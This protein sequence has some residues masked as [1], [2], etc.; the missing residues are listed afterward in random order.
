[1]SEQVDVL[2]GIGTNINPEANIVEAIDQLRRLFGSVDVSTI[3]TSAPVGRVDQ[4]TFLNG[5]VCI[6][7][8]LSP[9]ELKQ[10]LLSIEASQGRIRDPDDKCGPRTIDLDIIAYG[11]LVDDELQIPDSNL[12]KRWFVA[13]PCAELSPDWLHPVIGSTLHEIAAGLSDEI[14]G[15]PIS[16]D[17]S[18]RAARD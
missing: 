15:S 11:S 6:R 3:Y 12:A 1:M 9:W 14:D 16:L 13:I 7:T 2:I 10:R 8:D 18:T 4:P 17:V 5:A